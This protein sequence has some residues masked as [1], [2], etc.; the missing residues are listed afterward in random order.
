MPDIR[1]LLDDATARA[2]HA[3]PVAAVHRRVTRRAHRRQAAAAAATTLAIVV[4][5]GVAVTSSARRDARPVAPPAPPLTR[6]D[7]TWRR[8]SWRTV[9]WPAND[10]GPARLDALVQAHRDVFFGYSLH[11]G[12]HP[13]YDIGFSAGVDAAK[14]DR[15][16]GLAL[17]TVEWTSVRCALAATEYDRIA[18]ELLAA[19]WPS[20]A[21]IATD[22]AIGYEGVGFVDPCEVA[23][24]MTS[25]APA[26]ADL[27][28]ARDRWG[29]AVRLLGRGAGTR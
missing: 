11:T 27:A 29:S 16:I 3:D 21:G 22:R 5:T 19:D 10:H 7:T 6:L 26:T 24:E 2:P 14:W 13:F 28:Y 20:G 9:A 17:G 18:G 8:H 15:D 23:V 1:T 12:T 25:T 4:V